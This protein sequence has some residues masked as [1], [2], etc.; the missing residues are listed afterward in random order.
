[1]KRDAAADHRSHVLVPPRHG[2]GIRLARELQLAHAREQPDRAERRE[3]RLPQRDAKA[4]HHDRS[5][6]R[7]HVERGVQRRLEVARRAP[8]GQHADAVIHG[9]ERNQQQVGQKRHRHPELRGDR[10]CHLRRHRPTKWMDGQRR[11]EQQRRNHESRAGHAARGQVEDA[12]G[13]LV[14]WA[15]LL[16]DRRHPERHETDQ[17]A[18]DVHGKGETVQVQEVHGFTRFRRFTGSAGSTG[19]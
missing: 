17:A 12:S 19:S 11:R 1:M 8:C 13:A 9:D 5:R 10:R 4:E 2:R 6:N 16:D 3:H 7:R 18:H 15:A 14:Q